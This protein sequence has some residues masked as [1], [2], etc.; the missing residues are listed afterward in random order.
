[1]KIKYDNLSNTNTSEVMYFENLLLILVLINIKLH[2]SNV[3]PYFKNELS[4]KFI[5]YPYE[6]NQVKWVDTYIYS[7]PVSI[8]YSTKFDSSL[9]DRGGSHKYYN[10]ERDVF[11]D[12]SRKWCSLATTN[13]CFWD[14][15]DQLNLFS[16]LDPVPQPS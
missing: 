4:Y 16:S 2:I 15:S 3:N 1:M 5:L 11:K 7:L 14:H 12:W 13:C 6:L 9:V 10:G 8:H